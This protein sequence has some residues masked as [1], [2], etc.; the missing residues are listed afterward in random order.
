MIFLFIKGIINS[1]DLPVWLRKPIYLTY[2]WLFGCNL[3]EMDIED[4]QHYKNLS[5]FFRRKL[6]PGARIIDQEATLI[7]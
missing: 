5:Q 7:R 3:N 2:A 6:K 4:L 1:I